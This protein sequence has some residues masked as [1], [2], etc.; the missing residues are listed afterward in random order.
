MKLQDMTQA[1]LVDMIKGLQ[2]LVA[3]RYHDIQA[4]IQADTGLSDD[5]AR[6]VLSAVVALKNLDLDV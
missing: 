4:D 6:K 5:D 1:Q 3:G 2:D